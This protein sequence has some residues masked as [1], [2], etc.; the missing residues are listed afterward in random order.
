MVIYLLLFFVLKMCLFRH[1]P[2][3]IRVLP[4]VVIDDI[5]LILT[6]I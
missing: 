2:I 6:K 4:D 1:L 3:S 5:I